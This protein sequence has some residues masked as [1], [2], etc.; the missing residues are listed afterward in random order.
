MYAYLG[1]ITPAIVRIVEGICHEP[2]RTE[3]SMECT[4]SLSG[5]YQLTP[6]L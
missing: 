5:K 6:Q 2:G 1:V 4:S 3:Y